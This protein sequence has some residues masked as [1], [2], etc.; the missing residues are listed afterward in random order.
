MVLLHRRPA[1]RQQAARGRTKPKHLVY[2]VRK[3]AVK[4][5]RLEHFG[6][7]FL[8]SRPSKAARTYGPLRIQIVSKHEIA[9]AIRT[10]LHCSLVVSRPADLQNCPWLQMADRTQL[11][12]ALASFEQSYR[13]GPLVQSNRRFQIIGTRHEQRSLL[14]PCFTHSKTL[15]QSRYL[16]N[17]TSYDPASAQRTSTCMA[18]SSHRPIR[19]ADEHRKT[20]RLVSRFS[21]D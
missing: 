21:I 4:R 3:T 12:P 17:S 10:D 9:G 19:N 14:K 6:Y 7:S 11:R 16:F 5:P 13:P 15:L 1:H 8:C 2:V 20:D 18:F